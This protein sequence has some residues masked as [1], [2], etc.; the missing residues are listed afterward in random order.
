[1][2]SLLQIRYI[3][4]MRICRLLFAIALTC[5]PAVAMAQ[6]EDPVAAGQALYAEKC[7]ECH[8]AGLR[9]T[10]AT[11]DLRRLKKDERPR[12]DMAVLD[13]K[14][15][16]PPWRGVFNEAQLDHLWAYIRDRAYE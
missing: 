3:G 4:R 13:G 12:F 14:G 7:A 10:G 6:A 15:Q 16:M 5:A 8:G 1:L 11:F 2:T 9:N